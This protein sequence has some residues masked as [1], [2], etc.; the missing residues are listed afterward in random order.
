MRSSSRYRRGGGRK[1]PHFLALARD[2]AAQP[3]DILFAVFL[4]IGPHEILRGADR[5]CMA[6]WRVAVGQP[7]LWRYLVM[8]AVSMSTW[9]WRAAVHRGAGQCES[10]TGEERGFGS[11]L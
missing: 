11:G 1:R 7:L 2:W 3:Q 9:W 5:V 4:K 8:A 6:W 10:F